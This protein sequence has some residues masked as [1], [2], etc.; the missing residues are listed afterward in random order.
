M[1]KRELIPCPTN[2]TYMILYPSHVKFRAFLSFARF[3]R[4]CAISLYSYM[5]HKEMESYG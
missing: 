1:W 4:A 5:Q 3:S 2:Y